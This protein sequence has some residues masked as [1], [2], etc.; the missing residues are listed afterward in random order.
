MDNTLV[1]A[2][3]AISSAHQPWSQVAEKRGGTSNPASYKTYPTL[4]KAKPVSNSGSTS[5]IMDLRRGKKKTWKTMSAA[6]A[7]E[8]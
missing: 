4:V 5:G 2:L 3:Y 8:E 7:G 6:R 1:E